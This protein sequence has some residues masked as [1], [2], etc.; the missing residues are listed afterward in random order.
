MKKKKKLLVLLSVSIN[1]P[2]IQLSKNSVSPIFQKYTVSVVELAFAWRDKL[3]FKAEV[4]TLKLIAC[5]HSSNDD[6]KP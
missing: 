5:T 4:A 3:A 1:G 6:Y 2:K